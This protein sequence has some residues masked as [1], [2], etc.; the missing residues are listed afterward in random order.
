MVHGSDL[1]LNGSWVKFGTQWI[2]GHIWYMMFLGQIW[3]MMFLGKIWYMDGSKA[4]FGTL[5][6]LGSNLIHGSWVKFGTWM[7]QRSILIRLWFLGHIWHTDGSWVKFSTWMV[8]GSN[9]AH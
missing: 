7:V 9:L 6:V 2:L 5:I 8:L 1:V 3:Y 4:N